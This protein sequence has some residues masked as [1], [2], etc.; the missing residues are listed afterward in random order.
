M[1]LWG[2]IGLTTFPL[3][4]DTYMQLDCGF[5]ERVGGARVDRRSVSVP[6]CVLCRACVVRPFVSS[7]FDSLKLNLGTLQ[8]A[9]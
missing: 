1:T 9:R 6:F 8:G 5:E 2:R 7:N 4:P 3:R